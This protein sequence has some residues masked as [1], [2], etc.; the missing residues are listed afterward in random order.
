MTDKAADSVRLQDDRVYRVQINDVN[1][2][3]AM[4]ANNEMDAAWLPEPQATIARSNKHIMLMDSRR[5][6]AQMGVVAFREEIAANEERKKQIE[7]FLKAYDMACDSLNKRGI[8]HYAFLL[9]K[10]QCTCFVAVVSRTDYG[11]ALFESFEVGN[12]VSVDTERLIVNCG[13]GNKVCSVF[14]VK[15]VKVRLV[16][17]V[18]SINRAVGKSLVGE[19]IIIVNDDFKRV[20]VFFE[21]VF[22]LL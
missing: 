9:E 19:H 8:H 4:M 2:R 17:E 20:T 1:L 6:G 13:C 22:Y 15:R 7:A 10:E 21:F 18:V 16:L 14:L 12:A 5:T 11:C 3:W